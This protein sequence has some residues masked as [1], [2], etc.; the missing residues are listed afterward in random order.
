MLALR[1]HVVAARPGRETALLTAAQ[2]ALAATPIPAG[3]RPP[4]VVAVAVDAVMEG[5][6]LPLLRLGGADRLRPTLELLLLQEAA[7]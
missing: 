4:T 3:V 2:A 6:C 7:S 5:K 1:E